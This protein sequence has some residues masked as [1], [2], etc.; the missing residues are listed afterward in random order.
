VRELVY[1]E[2]ELQALESGADVLLDLSV[3][4]LF[5][6]PLPDHVCRMVSFEIHRGQLDVHSLRFATGPGSVELADARP[7][8]IGQLFAC[9][10]HT[11]I[12]HTRPAN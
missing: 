8:S 10:V 5:G 1:A 2:R 6:G 4:F 3:A 9:G 12:Y 7:G 11:L